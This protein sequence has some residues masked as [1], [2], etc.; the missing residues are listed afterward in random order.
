MTCFGRVAPFL[1]AVVLIAVGGHLAR[2]EVPDAVSTGP[3]LISYEEPPDAKLRPY[4]NELKRRHVLERLWGFMSPLR[5]PK[6]LSM[7]TAQCGTET[8]PYKSGGP[9]TICYEMVQHI[10]AISAKSTKDPIE[11]AQILYGTFV[12]AAL[13]QLAYAVFDELQVP[14]WGRAD[15][16]ADHLAA[17]MMTA[18]GDKVALTTIIGTAKFFEYSGRTWTGADFANTESPEAQR[19]YN[20]LC[21]AYGSDPITFSFLE[22]RPGPSALPKL[23]EYRARW[24]EREYLQVRHAFNLRIMPY[25]DPDRLVNVR[26]S[27]WLQPDELPE[28]VK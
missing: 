14:I 13:H 28:A 1:L 19:F 21:I 18:F 8:M 11:R 20:Y 16:A 12:E 24:C 17:L 4:Y 26:A 9:V 23:S 7:R 22:P 6:P 10:A 27:E 25:V 3:I 15:D 2:A 5:L